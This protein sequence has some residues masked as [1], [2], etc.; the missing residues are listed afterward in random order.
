VS[1]HILSIRPPA[2][3]VSFGSAII[4]HW[5]F[6]SP[7]S[8]LGLAPIGK[9]RRDR[10]I[11]QCQRAWRPHRV[12]FLSPVRFR[13]VDCGAPP[14]PKRICEENG[15]PPTGMQEKISPNP[16]LS[17]KSLKLQRKFVFTT[18]IHPPIVYRQCISNVY[19]KG[20]IPAPWMYSQRIYKRLYPGPLEPPFEPES[21]S[22]RIY[23]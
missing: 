21:Y 23:I 5:R 19:T 8:A 18:Y 13:L 10:S 9:A 14:F 22:K 17:S 12:R 1:R 16:K 11:Q 6:V 3:K 2:R 4:R 20:C 15:S 7:L